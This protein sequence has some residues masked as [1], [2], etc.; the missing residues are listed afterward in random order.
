[1]LSYAYQSLAPDRVVTVSSAV[2]GGVPSLSHHSAAEPPQLELLLSAMMHYWRHRLVLVC[3][4][5]F[6]DD[7]S[8][9]WASWKT[10]SFCQA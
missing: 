7:S 2:V 4:T 5:I 8:A 9:I 6:Q 1:M 10:L 3:E